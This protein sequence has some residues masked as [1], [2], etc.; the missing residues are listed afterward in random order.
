[1]AAAS[2][3]L[4]T[5]SVSSVFGS[6]NAATFGQLEVDQSKFIALTAPLGSSGHQLLILEQQ[7]DKKACWSTSGINP[8]VVEPLLLKFDF[9]GICGRSTDSNGY[10]I[11]IADSDLGLDYRLSIVERDRDL[12]LVEI[13]AKR[14]PRGCYALSLSWRYEKT[15]SK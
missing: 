15:V 7:S 10:S 8:E 13:S 12:V 6:T 3:L 14:S 2:A 5:I 4:G 1:M 11:R 9:T